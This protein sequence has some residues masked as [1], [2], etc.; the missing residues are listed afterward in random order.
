VSALMPDGSFRVRLKAPPVEGK[1][2]REL[3][4]FLACVLGIPAS[5]IRIVKGLTSRQKSLV[6]EGMKESDVHEILKRGLAR[7]G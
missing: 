5:S 6:I 2:N 3:V 1:A 4:A 7:D